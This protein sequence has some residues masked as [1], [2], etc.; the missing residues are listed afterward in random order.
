[1]EAV[2]GDDRGAGVGIFGC[3]AYD[4]LGRVARGDARPDTADKAVPDLVDGYLPFF[5]YACSDG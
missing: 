2:P 5:N 4:D 3:V 1:V